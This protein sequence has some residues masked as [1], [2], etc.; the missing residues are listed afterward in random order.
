VDNNCQIVYLDSRHKTQPAEN[1][2]MSAYF[3]SHM[4]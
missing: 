1:N 4:L 3:T 2:I